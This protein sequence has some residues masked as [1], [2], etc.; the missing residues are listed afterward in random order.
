MNEECPTLNPIVSNP[1]KN[2]FQINLVV[3]P[4]GL[5]DQARGELETDIG[6]SALAGVAHI[7]G[8]D[9]FDD[10]RGEIEDRSAPEA[11]GRQ[12]LEVAF[13]AT[14]QR[15]GAF[16]A[17]LLAGE[18]GRPAWRIIERSVDH[19]GTKPGDRYHGGNGGTRGRRGEPQ[20]HK[21]DHVGQTPLPGPTR[22][23]NAPR[24]RSNS[25]TVTGAW[26]INREPLREGAG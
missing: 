19:R 12:G 20:S 14:A 6:D 10:E 2:T 22:H 17:L 4:V 25:A 26:L 13:E 24:Q 11:Q 21:E 23:V 18:I 5:D 1:M 8:G 7:V 3:V 9:T 16:D 15:V